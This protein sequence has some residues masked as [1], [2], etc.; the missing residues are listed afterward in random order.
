[1]TNTTN[2]NAA[3]VPANLSEPVH[4]GL[5]H[6]FTATNQVFGILGFGTGMSCLS[7]GR[8]ITWIALSVLAV[9][10][11]SHIKQ[12]KAYIDA[13]RSEGDP[14]VRWH[15]LLR[16][17]YPATLGFLFV[18]LIAIGVLDSNGFVGF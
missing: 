7:H 13:L 3:E 14:A 8:L 5:G 2:V 16:E 10:W 15:R 4:D 17:T 18:A 9:I 1:M 11:H 12:Y 6:Y